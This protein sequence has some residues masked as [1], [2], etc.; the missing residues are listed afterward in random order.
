MD[1]I[2]EVAEAAAKRKEQI[3]AWAQEQ[4]KKDDAVTFLDDPRPTSPTP[5]EVQ[6]VNV[7]GADETLG[8]P[9]NED[10]TE[11]GEV[12]V[13]EDA[14]QV[15]EQADQNYPGDEAQPAQ[16]GIEADVAYED[17]E[18]AP[19]G[20]EVASEEGS[21]RDA[22]DSD[23]A[24]A[25]AQSDKKAEWVAYRVKTHGLTEEEADAKTKDELVNLK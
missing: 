23:A 16:K 18:G 10:A 11:G 15:S 25:P 17:P 4:I 6:K 19:T 20:P 24:E 3:R 5:E 22:E 8:G 9:A 14:A 13:Y 1:A 2:Q 7:Q 21:D 12:P